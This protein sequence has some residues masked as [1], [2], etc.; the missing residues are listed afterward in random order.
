MRRLS[1]FGRD[2]RG[3]AAIE[4]SFIA[5]VLALMY[6][7]VVELSSTI[8]ASRKVNSTASAVGDLVAQAEKLTTADVEAIFEAADAVMQP[9]EDTA[10]I[11]VTS[12]WMN[13]DDEIEV[14]WSRAR[15]TT[16]YACDAEIDPP[17]AVLQPGQSVIMAE[18]VYDYTPP[19]GHVVTG[20]IEMSETFYLRPRQSLEVKMT[21][22][23]CP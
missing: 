18:V 12:L 14:R 17:A 6:F 9:L 22:S 21:T 10:Q 19:F 11:R 8:E 4:F 3:A 2:R 15:N 20:A 23:P 5:P 13:Y 16:A 1:G 7:G